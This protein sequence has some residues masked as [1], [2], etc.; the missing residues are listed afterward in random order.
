MAG[1]ILVNLEPNFAMMAALAAEV[2][3]GV[4]VIANASTELV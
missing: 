3:A 4:I 2:V 1:V